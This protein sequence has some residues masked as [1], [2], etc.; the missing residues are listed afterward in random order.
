MTEW[1]LFLV[2]CHFFFY[3]LNKMVSIFEFLLQFLVAVLRLNQLTN[4]LIWLG[5]TLY[6]F[7]NLLNFS[8][9]NFICFLQWLDS[10]IPFIPYFNFLKLIDF[11]QLLLLLGLLLLLFLLLILLS[12]L[13]YVLWFWLR[14][15]IV[16]I[17]RI[18]FKRLSCIL[19][20]EVIAIFIGVE[21]VT[22]S[23]SL[24]RVTSH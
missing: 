5:N 8:R 4:L 24:S 6:L 15:Y 12:C 14:L 3:D 23:T 2:V 19:I 11:L 21:G 9:Q 7:P 22:E 18:K 20:G 17:I 1:F 10:H 16:H 13:R